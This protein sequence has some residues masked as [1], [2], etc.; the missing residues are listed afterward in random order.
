[1]VDTKISSGTKTTKNAIAEACL[2]EAYRLI[3]EKGLERLSLREVARRV[4]VS[5]QAPYKH[6]PSRDHLL[7]AVIARAYEEF[8]EALEARPRSDIPV[9]DLRAMGE[10]YLDFAAHHP[11]KYHL[12]FG[13]VLPD[14]ASH[15]EMTANAQATFALLVEGL[16]RARPG[17]Q[18]EP[19]AHVIWSA[20]HGCASLRQSAALEA[21][22]PTEDDMAA[23][24]AR[25]FQRLADIILRPPAV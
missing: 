9:L 22:G 14:P 15:P 21:L 25:L 16:R 23:A 13:A 8:A 10:A 11:L 12:M 7:A 2:E 6:F 20:L 18:V 3:A 4:G 24:E 17:D 1:M 5:H 19:D